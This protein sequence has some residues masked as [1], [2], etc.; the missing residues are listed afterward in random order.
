MLR[1]DAPSRTCTL[2]IPASLL[3]NA[4][5]FNIGNYYKVQI[6][7]DSASNGITGS[8]YLTR[9]RQYFSEWSSV[10]LIRAVPNIT[11]TMTGFDTLDETAPPKVRLVQ[12]GLVPLSG[13]ISSH[14]DGIDTSNYDEILQEFSIDIYNSD[15]ELIAFS[16]TVFTQNNA[17]PNDIY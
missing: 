3:K 17:R 15:D 5:F 6:R 9:Y 8:D 11:V 1:Y 12:P 7:F 2:K 16:G 4:D 14:A 13:N 10:C